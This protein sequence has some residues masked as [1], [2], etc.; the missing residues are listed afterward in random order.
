MESAEGGIDSGSKLFAENG[1]DAIWKSVAAVEKSNA[2]LSELQDGKKRALENV[3]D[4]YL[5]IERAKRYN[6]LLCQ[7][8]ASD[9]YEEDDGK[10]RKALNSVERIEMN[11]KLLHAGQEVC[12][13]KRVL[14]I[15]Q[16]DPLYIDGGSKLICI[17]TP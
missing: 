7:L 8:V 9:L 13:A 4:A 5:A 12:V 10:V 16:T 17:R 15:V 2:L 1:Q 14:E 6:D 11:D 3:R